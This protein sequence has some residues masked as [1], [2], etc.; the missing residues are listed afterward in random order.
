[1]ALAF[2]GSVLLWPSVGWADRQ[3][4]AITG[5]AQP[6][7]NGAQLA[8]VSAPTLNN[9]GQVVLQARLAEGIGG[10]GSHNDAALW[11][12][13]GAARESIAWKG[14]GDLGGGASYSSFTAA[15]IA[16]DGDVVFKAATDAGNQ[17]L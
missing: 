1:M 7:G 11:F 15:S 2:A 12:I 10:V 17:G 8:G 5:D 9:S 16:D 6:G 4:Q 14:A 3:L 13:D